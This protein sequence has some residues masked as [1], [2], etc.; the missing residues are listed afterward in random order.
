MPITEHFLCHAHSSTPAHLSAWIHFPSSSICKTSSY[1][2]WI[3]RSQLTLDIPSCVP[4]GIHWKPFPALLARYACCLLNKNKFRSTDH[5]R[6]FFIVLALSPE[7]AP[8]T[9]GWQNSRASQL[10]QI[11]TTLECHLYFAGEREG[12]K[13]MDLENIMLIKICQKKLRTM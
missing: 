2:T 1:T 5:H 10:Q 8:M 11:E 6:M 3:D 7:R 12:G 13:W 9:L 4:K